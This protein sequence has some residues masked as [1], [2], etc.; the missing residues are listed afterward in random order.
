MSKTVK[1][2]LAVVAVLIVI[3]IYYRWNAKKK[4]AAKNVVTG[5][6]VGVDTTMRVDRQGGP[7]TPSEGPVRIG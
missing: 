5:E 2:V 3:Y 7:G 4:A 6:R 1:I